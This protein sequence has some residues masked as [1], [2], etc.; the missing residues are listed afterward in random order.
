MR[1]VAQYVFEGATK[2]VEQADALLAAARKAVEAWLKGKGAASQGHGKLTL[3]DGRSAHYKTLETSCKSGTVSKWT[4]EETGQSRFSTNL[5]LARSGPEIAFSCSLSTGSTAAA[6]APSSFTARCPRVIKD[7][8]KLSP[9]WR[10]GATIVP[11]TALTFAGETQ[12]PDLVNRLLSPERALPVVV[13]SRYE[14]FLLHPNLLE[15]LASDVCGLAIVVDLDDKAAWAMTH[16]LGK[17]WSCYNGAIRIYWPHLNT[18]QNP[19]NHPLW[20]SE[21]L[22]YDAVDTEFASRRIRDIIRKRLFSV[23]SFALGQPVLFDRLEDESAKEALQEKLALAASADDYKTFAEEYAQENDN[24]RLQLRQER[25]NIKQLR[26]D[27]YQLQLAREWADAD[28]AVAPD[29]ATPPDCVQDAVTQA[30]RNYAQQLTFGDD[31][32]RG[33][34]TLAPNAGPP[35]K[36]LDYLRILASLVDVRRE[37]P[38]G[39]TMIQWLKRKGVTASSES[40][41]IQNNRDEMQRRTWHDGRDQRAFVTHLKPAEATPPDRCVRIYFDWDDASAKAVIGWVGRHP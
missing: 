29:E 32:E 18:R 31:V 15:L 28:E 3:P 4:L 13:A 8:L 19:R 21:R 27:L 22:M 40:E 24:L 6:I 39:D 34:F 14:G 36:I 23:S 16:Q 35:E 10:V 25:D 30:R 20:T 1:T 26:Q 11:Y 17:E 33:I 9:G 7:L 5:A 38:L 41:T 2:S 37:G 12:A